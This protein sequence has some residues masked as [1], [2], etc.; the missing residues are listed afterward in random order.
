MTSFS[1]FSRPSSAG[2]WAAGGSKPGEESKESVS[3]FTPSSSSSLKQRA[4]YSEIFI[5]RGD[6]SAA[7]QPLSPKF[8]LSPS[9]GHI[10]PGSAPS[11]SLPIAMFTGDQLPFPSPVQSSASVDGSRAPSSLHPRVMVPFTHHSSTLPP[12]RIAIERKRR[13]FASQSLA[14]LLLSHG[15]DYASH[16]PQHDHS[17]GLPSFLSLHLFDDD[18]YE[19]FTP[20]QWLQHG[21]LP[22][23]ALRLDAEGRGDYAACTVTA[24]N[25]ASDKWQLAYDKSDLSI[26]L[27]RL[28][29]CFDVEDPAVYAARVAAAHSSRRS[30]EATLR[31]ALYVDCMPI[32]ELTV[33]DAEQVNRVLFLAL[34]TKKMR[35]NNSDTTSLI[36]E[37]HLDYS[38]TINSIIYQAN[39]RDAALS[40]P[41][42]AVV[43]YTATVSIPAHDFAGH[44]SSFCFHSFLTKA[45]AISGLQRV[46]VECQKLRGQQLFVSQYSKSVRVDEFAGSQHS[47]R[48]QLVSHLHD[49]L[50]H[51]IAAALRQSLKDVD[52]GWLNLKEQSRE[53]FN[54]GKLSRLMTRVNYAI[55]D[56]VRTQVH[57]SLSDYARMIERTCQ[58]DVVV[59]GMKD[60]KLSRRQPDSSGAASASA[61]SDAP[62]P[63][64]TV[65][66]LFKDSVIQ[67]STPPA[68]LAASPL[69]V[70]DAAFASLCRLPQI[71]SFCLPQLFPV[72]NLSYISAVQREEP[73]V[74]ALAQRL[75]QL[76][77]AAVAPLSDYIALYSVHLPFLLLS[78]D[79]HCKEL[80]KTSHDSLD[81]VK[82]EVALYSERKAEVEAAIPRQVS[83]GL[84]LVNC[85]DVRRKVVNKYGEMVSKLLE[86]L[87]RLARAR[88]DDVTKQVKKLEADIRRVPVDIV[89]LTRLREF[90]QSVPSQ[91]NAL[92]AAVY[93]DVMSHFDALDGF[94]VK[95]SKELYKLKYAVLAYP[96][97]LTEMT[98]TRETQLQQ[99]SSLFLQEMRQQ[100]E[101]LNGDIADIEKRINS[102]SHLHDFEQ[103][104]KV[105][106][107]CEQLQHS[108]ATVV[109]RSRQYNSNEALFPSTAS[110]DY[111]IVTALSRR[112]D[113]YYL[114]FTTAFQW[115]QHSAQW[116]YGPFLELSADAIQAS[117]DGY[118]KN[119]VKVLKAKPIKDNAAHL[120]LASAC[121]RELDAFK[122]VLPLVL[123]LR[124]VGM[125]ERH[126]KILSDKLPYNF[127]FMMKDKEAEGS[128]SSASASGLP[129]AAGGGSSV[130]LHKLLE[131]YQLHNSLELIS[132]VSD[133]A[134]REFGIETSLQRMEEAWRGVDFTVVPYKATGTFVVKGVDEVVAQ[135]DEHTLTTQAMQFSPYKRVFEE[136]IARWVLKLNTVSE[137]VEEWLA[138]QK[139]WL[140]LQSIFASPDINK[141]L[142]AE[143][144]RFTAVNKSWRLI[145]SQA[146]AAPDVL[147][148]ADSLSLLT[149]LK[150]S[151][152]TLTAVQKKLSDYLDKKRSLFP[153]FYFLA[154]DELLAILSQTADPL[155]VQPHLKKCFENVDR[156]E[157]SDGGAAGQLITAM[158]SAEGERVE[159]LR[160]IAVKD[161]N[162]EDWLG[163]VES[164]MKAG[165]RHWMNAAIAAYPAVSRSDWVRAWPGQTVL[166]GSQFHWTM[167]MEQALRQSG[168]DG[169]LRYQQRWLS[170]LADM[171]E[172]VR[173]KLSRIQSLILGALIV[174]DVHARDV[175][176]RLVGERV[177]SVDDFGWICQ[178]RYYSQDEALFCQMVQSRFPYGYEYLGNTARLV[179]TPLT[180]RCY[181]TL[182]SAI[183]LHLG[184]A[185]SG[186]AGTG[187]TETVKDLAKAVAKYCVVFN[188]RS[189]AQH[190][191]PPC[192]ATPPCTST[193]LTHCRL[194]LCSA[195]G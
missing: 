116:R 148:F 162:V 150:D 27:H 67:Y 11:S 158:L 191:P 13:Q 123:A 135:L 117:V 190:Q 10:L 93:S 98:A 97:Q 26:S 165:V 125:K 151:N 15:I 146:H 170:Q 155:A 28:F 45:E 132:K 8:S 22:A 9:T 38:R 103:L 176:E 32:D 55:A 76:L 70:F 81:A 41:A 78:V 157:F 195:T 21:P 90:L 142:P 169:L 64:F 86:L 110:T 180:D 61:P 159:F 43:P 88:C 60:I 147:T 94:Q 95:V 91:V 36:N 54:Y 69:E 181:L 17:T 47:C 72:N 145:M 75:R 171:V 63:L 19:S 40:A 109:A 92:R 119:I 85:E 46:N 65:D 30:A 183:S 140:N 14:A 25:A 154:N 39:T 57:S 1:S 50:L 101:E 108:I 113:D 160:P 31:S 114:L 105:N 56:T 82:R 118:H 126:W 188:C 182:M 53:I 18:E 107:R 115:Q 12:R 77:T 35:I 99:D 102:L 128:E 141:Q 164:A 166:N 120:S 130:T 144:K 66:L 29:L 139:L 186:P 175:H 179:I 84:C 163:E 131:E 16:S 34:N 174:L 80:Q 62:P 96:K 143:G 129:G 44:F 74:E 83:L 193:Q 124:N 73:E 138:V 136:R 87:Q 173:G 89:E 112:F 4:I 156:L 189:A 49:K 127:S 121:K 100:Q 134:S 168:H 111:A 152:A 33:M 133:V 194:C 52:K 7:A 24:Y 59:S 172:L 48:H 187:K 20:Q 137:V 51:N 23:K 79:E 104:D 153:R 184:G 177:A 122:A 192:A 106:E 2:G 42:A 37:M 167:E 161:R 71:E 58:H 68:A 178:L 3:F 149:K 6:S 185:P 5:Q